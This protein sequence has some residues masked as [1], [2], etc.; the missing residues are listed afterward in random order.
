ME[1]RALLA[2][3]LSLLV[4]ILWGVFLAKISPPPPP[5]E[6]TAE[7]E[8]KEQES[9]PP[10]PGS[11]APSLPLPGLPSAEPGETV[12]GPAFPAQTPPAPAPELQ[13][14]IL[15]DVIK[16]NTTLTFSSRGS[17]LKHVKLNQ[18]MNLEG[19]GPIDLIPQV[20]GAPYPLTLETGHPAVDRV[21]TNGHFQ[22]SKEFIEISEF[23]PSSDLVFHLKHPSGA[24]TRGPGPGNASGNQG[25]RR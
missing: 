22:P 24:G 5:Q 17:V 7:T 10:L 12:T 9:V 3:G 25:G 6:Q 1:N 8:L 4:F 18:Y 13:K 15:V 20:P 23:N 14:E 11:E 19:D 21:L 16:G 2:F